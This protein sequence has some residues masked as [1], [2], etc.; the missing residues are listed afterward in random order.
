DRA[1]EIV[2]ELSQAHPIELINSVNPYRIEGQKTAAFEV[3]DELSEPP[4]ALAIPV[5][6]AGN[7]TAWWRGF[8]ESGTAPLLYG[9]QAEGAAPLVHGKRV[10]N[11]ETVASAI[12]IGNPA[13]WEEAMQAVTASR[14][15]IA[16]VS[17][18]QILDAYRWIASTEGIFC[19]P[20]SAASV[21][22]ILAHGLPAAEG[23]RA[24]ESVVCVLT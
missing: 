4:D 3:C 6:N 8:Q 5:G 24:P 10:E 13:R 11:P 23:G 17:D 7:I 15:R 21:A 22:G 19:E 12:R 2:R 20:A 9:F 1:L 14:G 16:A 18:A